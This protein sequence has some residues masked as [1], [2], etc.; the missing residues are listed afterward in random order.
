[1]MTLKKQEEIVFKIQYVCYIKMLII[2]YFKKCFFLL[3]LFYIYQ[4]MA[5]AFVF[6]KLKNRY[7]I[8]FIYLKNI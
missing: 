2:L 7:K 6:I 5:S 8:Y 3:L 1:M 4:N